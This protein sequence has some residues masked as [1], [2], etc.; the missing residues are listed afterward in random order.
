MGTRMQIR[1]SQ[2]KDLIFINVFCL[3]ICIWK[4][5]DNVKFYRPFSTG[6]VDRDMGQLT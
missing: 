2:L 5:M 6:T 3:L 1:E 4:G